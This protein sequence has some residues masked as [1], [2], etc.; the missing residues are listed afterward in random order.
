MFDDGMK[1][2]DGG[3]T[4][5][6]GV[7]DAATLRS[8]EMNNFILESLVFRAKGEIVSLGIAS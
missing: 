2:H 1:S 4:K 3:Y 8:E 7:G 6:A 5:I